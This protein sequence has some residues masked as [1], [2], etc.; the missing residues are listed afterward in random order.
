MHT[1]NFTTPYKEFLTLTLFFFP[2]CLLISPLFRNAE[3]EREDHIGLY[4]AQSAVQIVCTKGFSAFLKARWNASGQEETGSAGRANKIRRASFA[5][6]VVGYSTCH[7]PL[8][9]EESRVLHW[10]KYREARTHL[11]RTP[12]MRSLRCAVSSSFLSFS[13]YTR[14]KVTTLT[15]FRTSYETRPRLSAESYRSTKRNRSVI[16]LWV[17]SRFYK[18][19]I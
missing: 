18:F 10:T 9:R 19:W 1:I 14:M 5:I 6:T 8:V 3:I 7:L 13:L 15:R 16:Y 12:P 4:I 11:A 2:L 17:E